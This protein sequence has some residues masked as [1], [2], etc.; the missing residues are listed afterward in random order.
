[1][2]ERTDTSPEPVQ[3]RVL[4][5][6][7]T[8]FVAGHCIADL[9][10]RGYAVRGTVRRLDTADVAHLRVLGE[11]AG[12]SL[13]LTEASLDADDG[14]AQAVKGCDYV[15]H[16]AS[17]NPPRQPENEDELIHPA[18]DG[19][20]RV[21]RAAA[22]SGT[23][24]RVVLTSSTDAI[25]RGYPKSE[26]RLRTEADWTNPDRSAAYPRSKFFAERAAWDFAR[27]H[28]LELVTINPALILGPLQTAGRRTSVELIQALLAHEIQAVPR[29]GFAVT[30]VR[31]VAVA[32]RLA[33]ETPA[34]DGNRYIVAGEHLWWREIATLL[35]AE[36][37]PRGYRI[38]TGPL[39]TPLLRLAA[40]FD[41]RLKLTLGMIGI[42]Q[43]V[44]AEKA[45]TELGWHPRPARE[46]IIETA[47]SLLAHGLV[48]RRD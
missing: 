38:P 2:T 42:P 32:H 33:M 35:A 46:T 45:R 29:L 37:R 30:D 24:R 34:A 40:R 27:D 3:T 19:T 11:R 8:G 31:D 9:L 23:V 41:S 22:A 17:P 4:V 43:L 16:V 13:E 7:A 1:M 28:D 12:G 25:T 10:S 20:L 6:G 39:P 48:R 36:Y 44:S 15:W 18:V 5:T 21:L 26:V 47:E 14:W